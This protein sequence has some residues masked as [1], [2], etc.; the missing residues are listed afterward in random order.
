MGIDSIG[1]KPPSPPP[2]A[3]TG[4]GGASH[5]APVGRPFEVSGVRGAGRVDAVEA[6]RTALE[7]L[8]AGDIDVNGYVDIKVNEATS[9]LAALPAAELERVRSALR[10]RMAGDPTLVDLVRTATGSIPQPSTDE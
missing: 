1:K 3:A 4:V 6:P 2:P 8:R 5:G 9:H 7:R 10:D